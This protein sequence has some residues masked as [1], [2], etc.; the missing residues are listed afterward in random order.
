MKRLALSLILAL[1]G[2]LYIKTLNTTSSDQP[3]K[4]EWVGKLSDGTRIKKSDLQSI[5][6]KHVKWTESVG[7]REG[8]RADLSRSQPAL[9]YRSQSK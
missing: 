3:I 4:K 7:K 9:C 6:K 2:I 8:E 5:I 1:I